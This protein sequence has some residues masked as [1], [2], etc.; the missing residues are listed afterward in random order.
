MFFTSGAK[1]KKGKRKGGEERQEIEDGGK[2]R[3]RRGRDPSGVASVGIVG[4][5]SPCPARACRRRASVRVRV[6]DQ[7]K[8]CLLQRS[9]PL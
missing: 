5:A 6:T 2:R 7:N 9:L 3:N 4:V 8:L 1:P